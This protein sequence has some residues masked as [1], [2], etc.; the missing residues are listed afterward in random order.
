M[1]ESP[2]KNSNFPPLKQKMHLLYLFLIIIIGSCLYGS[3]FSYLILGFIFPERS[4]Y[5]FSPE[6]FLGSIFIIGGLLITHQ[7]FWNFRRQSI[8]YYFLLLMIIWIILGMLIKDQFTIRITITFLSFMLYFIIARRLVADY[9]PLFNKTIQA[10][11]LSIC[12]IWPVF[13]IILYTSGKLYF[14]RHL[15]YTRLNIAG[16]IGSTDLAIFLGIQ[17]IYLLSLLIRKN[18]N[19]F[20]K[21]TLLALII[22]NLFI[23]YLIFSLAA[24]FSYFIIFS[25]YLFINSSKLSS[26]FVKNFKTI[27]FLIVFLIVFPKIFIFLKDSLK[28]KYN[29]LASG[30]ERTIIYSQLWDLAKANPLFGIKQIRIQKILYQEHVPH[31]NILGIAAQYGIPSSF[32]YLLFIISTI[33]MGLHY[34]LLLRS[35]KTKDSNFNNMEYILFLSLS[36]FIYFQIRGLPEDTWTFKELYFW[37][38]VLVGLV[39]RIKANTFFYKIKKNNL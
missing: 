10:V 1:K 35:R 31:N 22:T 17:F 23:L 32:F 14:H 26:W 27:L 4:Q 3:H 8:P 21:I 13:M 11:T 36:C 2:K 39:D 18:Y 28:Y 20:K 16:G 6:L 25:L 29:L 15:G 33:I 5:H 12:F 37:T 9:F 19:L 7:K 38:G 24:I 30:E 34:F